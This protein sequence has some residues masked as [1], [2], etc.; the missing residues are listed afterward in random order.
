MIGKWREEGR[1]FNLPVKATLRTY[2]IDYSSEK[3]EKNT[4]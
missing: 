4:L 3:W 1:K 2:C